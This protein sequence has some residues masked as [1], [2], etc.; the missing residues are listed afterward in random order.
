M[1][2]SYGNGTY[3]EGSKR[4][5]GEI[6]L[7]EHKLYLRTSEGDLAQTYVPLEKIEKVTK[8]GSSA[9]FHVRPS[10]S[11]RYIAMIQGESKYIVELIKDI[12]QRRGLKKKFL[13]KEWIDETV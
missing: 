2:F 3:R 13:R 7:G 9:E 5:D 12:V 4:M 10:L 1:E 8:R 11:F 6:V